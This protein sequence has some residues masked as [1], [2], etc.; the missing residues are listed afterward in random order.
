MAQL[1]M[2]NSSLSPHI[3]QVEMKKISAWDQ[4]LCGA[5]KRVGF[6]ECSAFLTAVPAACSVQCRELLASSATGR[7]HHAS[8]GVVPGG[9]GTALPPDHPA[10]QLCFGRADRPVQPHLRQ[11]CWQGSPQAGS[12]GG[13]ARLV[14]INSCRSLCVVQGLYRSLLT[15]FRHQ[16]ASSIAPH[17]C[18]L[19]LGTS[20]R[21]VWRGLG[22]M[23]DPIR[24]LC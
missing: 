20:Y 8:E 15:L 7:G 14:P 5:A 9:P 18:C 22:R 6:L 16:I 11:S 2:Q 4:S 19:I 23:L 3:M 10:Q 12:Q 21:F 17:P 24:Q 1:Q 13:P